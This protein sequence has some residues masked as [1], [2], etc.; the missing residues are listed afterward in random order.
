MDIICEAKKVFDDEI[1]ALFQVKNIIDTNFEIVATKIY[2]CSGKVIVTGMG[3]PG[4]IARKMAATFSSLGICSVFMHPGEALH[5]DMGMISSEDILIVIS[6]SGESDEV[7]TFLPELVRRNIFIIGITS[8]EK[9][10][11]A[12]YCN[13]VQILPKVREADEWGLAPTSSTTSELVY[14][15]A[16]AVVVS[17]LKGYQKNDFGRN[18]PAGSLGKKLNYRVSDIMI[19]ESNYA[20]V[21]FDVKLKDAII[22]MSGKASTIV[23]FVDENSNLRGIVTDGDLRR[24]LERGEDIYSR[25]AVEVMTKSPKCVY[26]D[27][28]AIDA[29]SEMISNRFSAMPVLSRQNTLVGIIALQDILRIGI[30]I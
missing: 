21:R 16:L 6:W 23:T 26:E 25:D 10:T 4:H 8:N 24:L 29:M 28:M 2:E 14:G 22:E 3:K 20:V 18:H 1:N 13:A 30:A 5:G 27:E 11:L 12:K 17:K 9:S 15:D 19:K 7:I